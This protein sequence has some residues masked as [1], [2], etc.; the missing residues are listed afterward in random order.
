[1]E[2]KSMLGGLIKSNLK[3]NYVNAAMLL[4][5]VD[6]CGYRY[7]NKREKRENLIQQSLENFKELIKAGYWFCVLF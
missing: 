5:V 1:M 7:I 4:Y 3:K 6:I 2:Q